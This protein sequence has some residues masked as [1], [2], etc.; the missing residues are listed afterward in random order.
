M[1]CAS[2]T[3]LQPSAPVQITQSPLEEW[4][5]QWSPD[6]KWLSYGS[7][8][9]GNQNVAVFHMDTQEETLLTTGLP[10]VHATSWSP[11]GTQL[12]Y[13]TSAPTENGFVSHIYVVEVNQ[14][15]IRQV[16]HEE[17]IDG[18]PSWS[19]DGTQLAFPSTRSGAFNLWIQPLDGEAAVM[20]TDHP[21]RDHAPEWS[22]DGRHLAFQSDRGETTSIWV[23]DVDDGTLTPV[24]DDEGYE[25]YP[26]WSPNGRYLT[27]DSD[28]AGS[29]DIWIQPADGGEAIP[30]TSG[31]AND[32]RPSWSPDG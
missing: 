7:G 12:A 15:T 16:T 26:D 10:F 5:P 30:I 25:S 19:P 14:R 1:G 2:S 11:G 21:E 9:D 6:G 28:R 32:M 3:N 8:E 22:P 29:S 17:S 27:Y 20:V 23:L 13:V 31:P 24:T 18:S 4:E